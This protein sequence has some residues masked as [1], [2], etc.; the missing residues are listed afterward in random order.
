MKTE[1][2]NADCA[3]HFVPVADLADLP[4]FC[5]PVLK[6]D[7]PTMATWIDTW[8]VEPTGDH[9]TDWN[10]GQ[11]FADIAVRYARAKKEPA[12]INFVLGMMQWKISRGLIVPG[13]VEG[14]FFARL[15]KLA[16]VGSFD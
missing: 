6:L 15:A 8:A 11:D 7:D 16:C 13:S 2:A 4:I 1:N 9:V 10:M 12:W 14:G 5:K 3:L